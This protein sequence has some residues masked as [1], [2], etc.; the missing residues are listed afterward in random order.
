MTYA[1]SYRR[2]KPLLPSFLDSAQCNLRL[3][4]RALQMYKFTAR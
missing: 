2:V 1:M 3:V 4:R